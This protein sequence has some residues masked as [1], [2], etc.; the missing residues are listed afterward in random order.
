MSNF[1]DLPDGNAISTE[2]I[3]SVFHVSGRGVICRDDENRIVAYVRSEDDQKSLIVRDLLIKAVRD[4][5]RAVQPDWDFFRQEA[6]EIADE[7]DES[8]S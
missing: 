5:Y 4:G 1:I 6:T 2:V 7:N 3:R 8:D